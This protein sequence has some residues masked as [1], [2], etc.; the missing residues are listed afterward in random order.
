MMKTLRHILLVL[1]A[2]AFAGVQTACACAHEHAAPAVQSMAM[3]EGHDHCAEM[4]AMSSGLSVD[5]QAHESWKAC[6]HG[7][8]LKSASA[9]VNPLVIS[10]PLLA[11]VPVSYFAEVPRSDHVRLA[12]WSSA[13]DPPPKT[14][15]QA[16]TRFLN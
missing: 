7:S 2:L 10:A 16:K 8:S 13:T 5:H 14:P 15:M 1:S 12:S 6:D 3:A 4:A 9:K 11:I